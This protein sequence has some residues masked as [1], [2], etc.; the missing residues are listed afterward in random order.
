MAW[1][2]QFMKTLDP[3]S[4]VRE[5]E[6]ELAANTAWVVDKLWNTWDKLQEWS[7]LTDTQARAFKQLA[8]QFIIDKATIYDTKYSDWIRRL[9][10][11]GIDTNVFP[12][13]ISDQMRAT[14]ESDTNTTIDTTK[15]DEELLKSYFG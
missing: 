8:K 13:S 1:V 7:I 3:Q 12:A 14:L 15:S 10:Q 11:Q 6:F 9:D 2:F 4:V 5:S